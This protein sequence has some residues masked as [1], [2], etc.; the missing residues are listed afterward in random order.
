MIMLAYFRMKLSLL[1]MYND[2]G[3]FSLAAGCPLPEAP[4]FLP[5][6]DPK[7]VTLPAVESFDFA[8]SAANL[9][10]SPIPNIIL[11]KYNR[12]TDKISDHRI[13]MQTFIRQCTYRMVTSK[14]AVAGGFF[15]LFRMK[16]GKEEKNCPLDSLAST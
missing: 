10:I 1:N 3:P 8:S 13:T 15:V 6:L 11:I 5:G 12:F 7:L 9:A 4:I 14:R 2:D 16:N